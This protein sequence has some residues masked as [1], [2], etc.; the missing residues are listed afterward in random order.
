MRAH[1]L[2]DAALLKHAGQF[3]WL[4]IDTENPVNA[5]FNA[6]FPTEGVPTFLVIDPST[7]KLTLSWYGSATVAQFG[8][9]M[10]DARR[11]AA[12]GLAGAD[13]VLARADEANAR[14]DFT[15]AA[16]YYTQALDLGGTSWPKRGRVIES[17]VQAYAFDKQS[18]A[19]TDTVLKDAPSMPRDR[20]F[21]NVVY[22]GLECAQPGTPES[23]EIEKLAEE[24]VTI[25][26]IL[27]DDISQLYGSLAFYYRQEKNDAAANRVTNARI[28]YLKRELAKAKSPEARL[29]LDLQYVSA[30]NFLGKPELPV[31]NLERD[32]RELPHDYNPPYLLATQLN[33]M[34][35][36]DE[37]LASCDRA[38]QLAY[39]G[40]KLRAYALKGQILERKGDKAGARRTYEE[41]LEFAKTLPPSTAMTARRRIEAALS[42]L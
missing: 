36:Y 34:K 26:N 3:V 35:Q 15:N 20:S 13:I 16:A 17:L 4:S 11:V 7:E 28:E 42:N 22:F 14:K 2:N 18:K 19:C 37:A 12:G 39:G 6:K 31:A 40:A 27:S 25:P 33:A 10:D 9:M 32:E 29:A 8:T 41:G 21:V 23:H 1:V 38:M 5:D 30:A 24:A